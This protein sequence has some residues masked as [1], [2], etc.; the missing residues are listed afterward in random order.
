MIAARSLAKRFGETVALADVSLEL[1][2]GALA[3][4]AGSIVFQT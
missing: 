3:D 2:P 4:A 1:A